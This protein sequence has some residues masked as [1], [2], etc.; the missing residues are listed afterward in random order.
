[1]PGDVRRS[2]RIIY[3][4]GALG[5]ASILGLYLLTRTV[6]VPLGPG[7]GSVESVG[8]VDVV[9]KMTKLLA[10]AELVVLLVKSRP[11]LVDG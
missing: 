10:I 8:V 2:R 11:R 1:M 5:N 3:A 9:A 4:I 7:S 6:G